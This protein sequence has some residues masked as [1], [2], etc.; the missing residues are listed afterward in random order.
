MNITLNTASPIY[1]GID[2]GGFFGGDCTQGRVEYL[3]SFLWIDP[4][5]MKAM[6]VRVVL[7]FLQKEEIKLAIWLHFWASK[8]EMEYDILL[9][10][11]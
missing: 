2:T 9:K 3:D 10:S 6:G 11:L 8:N 1:Q 4:Q 7:I 5:L